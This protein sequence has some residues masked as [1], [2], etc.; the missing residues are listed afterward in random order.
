MKFAEGPG[1]RILHNHHVLKRR[2]AELRLE[3]EACQHILVLGI[4]TVPKLSKSQRGLQGARVGGQDEGS[5]SEPHGAA[6]D[7]QML[8]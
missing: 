3:L 8:F 4:R 7:R 2:T 6:M 1:R 5:V